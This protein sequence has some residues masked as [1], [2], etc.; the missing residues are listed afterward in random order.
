MRFLST[1][2]KAGT[3]PSI[4]SS[5][6]L[7]CPG[8]SSGCRSTCGSGGMRFASTASS[9]RDWR[10][11]L[12]RQGQSR[13]GRGGSCSRADAFRAR[14]PPARERVDRRRS[15]RQPLVP[16]PLSDQPEWAG[17]RLPDSASEQG[18]AARRRTSPTR[19]VS[20]VPGTYNGNPSLILHRRARAPA[21]A[22]RHRHYSGPALNGRT[23]STAT[24]A[25]SAPSEIRP[26]FLCNSQ[27]RPQ[28]LCCCGGLPSR[29][30]SCAAR[31]LLFLRQNSCGSTGR[32]IPARAGPP[33]RAAWTCQAVDG[34][35]PSSAG[36]SRCP[37]F[38]GPRARAF[39]SVPRS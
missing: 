26:G 25:G 4:G 13:R 32:F 11:A 36:S 14:L 18:C 31:I 37:P 24:V 12:A 27:I 1:F 19:T 7:A 10:V 17:N 6:P 33:L 39:P 5:R 8:P 15:Q 9:L 21:G 29:Y 35:S 2:P 28:F 30:S 34:A 23:A 16:A 3:L 20:D 38:S 22:G